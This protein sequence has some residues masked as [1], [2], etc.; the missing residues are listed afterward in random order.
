M[1]TGSIDTFFVKPGIEKAS[2]S[3]ALLFELSA[4]TVHVLV[5]LL[6]SAKIVYKTGLLKFT[7]DDPLVCI[8]PDIFAY[9]PEGRTYAGTRLLLSEPKG[10]VTLTV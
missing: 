2:I 8:D 7:L 5:M 9:A 6:F 10:T 3:A 4:I 1:L